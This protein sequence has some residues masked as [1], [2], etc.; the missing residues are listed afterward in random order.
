[1]T[2]YLALILISFFLLSADNISPGTGKYPQ[3]YFRSPV[4]F[5]ISLSGSFGELRRNHFHSGI[6][7]RT[8]GSVGKPV[9]SVADGYVSRVFV[10]PNGF[11][12]ALYVAHPNGYTSVYG[13]LLKFSGATAAWV[14]KK[15][16]EQESFSQDIQVPAGLL[17]V[18]KGEVIALSGNSGS[19]AGP[20]IH[21][22]I[23]ESGSQEVINPL[24]FGF[25]VPDNTPP[26]VTAVRI[27]PFDA[28]AMVNYS[29]R[30]LLLGVKGG[31]GSYAVNVTDTVKVSGNIIFGIETTDFSDNSGMKNGVPSVVL[32]IDNETVYSHHLEKFAFANTRYVNS[33]V[34]YP[35]LINGNRKIQRSYVA[36][37]NRNDIYGKVK[38]RG[39]VSFTD[40]RAHSV[41]YTVTDIY[42]NSTRLAFTVKS[43][44]PAP[45]RPENKTLS[46]VTVMRWSEDNHFVRPDLKFDVPGEAL[47]DDLDFVYSS[48]SQ[49]PRTYS[50]L[51][52]VHNENTPLHVFCTLSIKPTDLPRE[53]YS[54]AVVVQV[55][56]GIKFYS[57][58]GKWVNGFLETQIRD[59]GDYAIAVDE[60]PPV[61]RAV[62]VKPG[63]NISR[64]GSIIMKV[65]DNLSGVKT[66][67]GTVNGNWILFDYDAKNN[68]LTYTFDE[69]LPKG[70]L[71][72][73]LTVTDGVGNSSSYSAALLR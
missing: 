70:K 53:L 57:K 3:N 73:R 41:V 66:Y 21:F 35:L 5:P 28:N 61:I 63:K 38:D 15:Q 72:F 43:H 1:M 67:R 11:G 58:G 23:R 55:D 56:N 47:Y 33:L 46:G 59:L 30:P 19:S 26:K 44:P 29:D 18:K 27:F 65:S 24:E 4:D 2:R 40:S 22:E 34:D 36:P 7:I 14:K 64:Q 60:E 52:H 62:N 50:R 8:G 16:Y 51:H 45:R 71:D 20:H 69:H 12:K 17:K 48:G 25:D 39:I 9:K 68:L 6:D 37:N 54:K 32:K 10:S 42:G 31:N 49:I 13:H